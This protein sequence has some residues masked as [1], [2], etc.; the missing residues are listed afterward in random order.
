MIGLNEVGMNEL[1]SCC[2]DGLVQRTRADSFDGSSVTT[3]AVKEIKDEDIHVPEEEIKEVVGLLLQGLLETKTLFL[4][5]LQQRVLLDCAKGFQG[6]LQS[7]LLIP[8]LIC[9]LSIASFMGMRVGWM[10]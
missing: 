9:L 10:K 3:S 8:L 7:R 5:G 1:C 6:T 2:F 4:G